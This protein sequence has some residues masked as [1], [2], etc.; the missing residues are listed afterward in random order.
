[1]DLQLYLRVVWRRR[2]I[3]LPAVVVGAVLAVLSVAT[4]GS[5]WESKT[6][7]FVT[8]QGFPWGRAI[9][10]QPLYVPGA[11]PDD[12]ALRFADPNRFI[13]LAILYS[14]LINGDPIRALM[15][16]RDGK[17]EG[18]FDAAPVPS[19]DGNGFVP[20][21]NISARA[22]SKEEAKALAKR[23][24]K[25]FQTYLAAEQ[26]GS[27]IP[28]PNRVLVPVVQQPDKPILFSGPSVTRPFFIFMLI[29]MAA[30]GLAFVLENTRPPVRAVAADELVR[31]RKTA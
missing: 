14:E 23:V 20:M 13:S 21:I 19:A 22:Y 28:K 30:V 25:A 12:P 1:M 10:D 18:E 6:R 5:V 4:S 8:Q 31:A 2:W 9:A 15:I 16:K 17:I 27:G 7:L 11:D 29:F 3:V 24:S 26:E